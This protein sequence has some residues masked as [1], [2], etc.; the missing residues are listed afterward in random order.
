MAN[1]TGIT[2]DNRTYRVRVVYNTIGRSFRIPEGENSGEMLSGR[3]ELDS[4]GTYYDYQMDVEP[5]PRYPADYDDFFDA[6]SDP[7]GIHTVVLPYGQNTVTLQV[8][9][10]SGGDNS[11]G[12]LAGVRRWSGLRV[13]FESIRPSRTPT[14]GAGNIDTVAQAVPSI[15][16][17]SEGLITASATQLAGSVSGGTVSAT[18]QMSTQPAATITPGTAAKTAVAAGKYTTGT[19]NVAGDANLKPQNIKSGVSIFGVVGTLPDGTGK[20]DTSDA[21][22]TAAD[23]LAGKT[24]YAKGVKVTGAIANKTASD[25]IASEATVIVPAG[26]YPSQVSKSVSLSDIEE[27]LATL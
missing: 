25:L 22:A 19:V 7:D 2:M 18:K 26:Y 6:I 20:S 21:T 3:Y 15:S 12:V 13:K 4:H 27:A 14:E 11:R 23:I 8:K 1:L 24:A 10:S 17:T 5:D 16:V 9:V